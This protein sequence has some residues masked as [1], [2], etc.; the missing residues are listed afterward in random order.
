MTLTDV[1]V[2]QIQ[3]INGG[4]LKLDNLTLSGSY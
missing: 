1:F 2:F 3:G 4:S